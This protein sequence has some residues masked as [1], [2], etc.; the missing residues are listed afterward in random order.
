MKK[1]I[2]A[3]F[4]L[5]VMINLLILTLLSMPEYASASENAT[6]WKY[7]VRGD[8]AVV[9]DDIK[10]GLEKGQFLISSEENLAK[11][12]ENNKHILGGEKN[13]NTI[14][15]KHATAIHFCSII[16]NHEVFNID[17]DLSYLCPFKVV[18]YTM[19]KLPQSVTIITLRPTYLLKNDEREKVRDIGKRI[20][21]R[22]IN[23][24][25][26]GIKPEI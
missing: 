8:F 15:F 3:I 20:E 23:A 24:I 4:K 7:Q 5:L 1:N 2:T 26:N 18:V 6:I 11:G 22:I 9:V 19:D 12:L 17:M 16:F 13:W 21:K 14:G 25:M 10:A